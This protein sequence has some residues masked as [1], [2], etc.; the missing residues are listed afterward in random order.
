MLFTTCHVYTS[1][2]SV[3]VYAGTICVKN[4]YKYTYRAKTFFFFCDT[5]TIVYIY[6]ICNNVFYIILLYCMYYTK[7]RNAIGSHVLVHYT[8]L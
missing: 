2:C 8:R 5:P 7:M 6:N 3:A 1:T 4:V